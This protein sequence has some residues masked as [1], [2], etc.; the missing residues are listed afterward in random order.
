[1]RRWRSRSC[2][3]RPDRSRPDPRAVAIAALSLLEALLRDG[4]VLLAVDDAQ[5]LDRGHGA[6]AHLRRSASAGPS[7]PHPAGSDRSRRASAARPVGR[8]PAGA[9]PAHP[10]GRHAGQRPRGRDPGADGDRDIGPRGQASRGR[11][12]RQSLLR[13]RDRAGRGPRRPGCHRPVPSHPEEPPRGPRHASARRASGGKPRSAARRGGRRPADAR[14]PRRRR[15]G[16]SDAGAA[17][18][19]DRRRSR[20]GRRRRRSLHAPAVPVGAVR[21]RLEGPAP[22][23][24]STSRGPHGRSRGASAAPRSVGGVHGRGDRRR[25]GR[26]GG[27]GAGPRRPRRGGG[28][29]RARDPV[30]TALG[31]P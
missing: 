18:A 24:A 12:G 3:G 22:H 7:R 28:T 26:G 13:A 25:A 10:A 20:R 8:A 21:E 14:P 15:R 29:V 23:R 11:L 19:R 1:M 17:P 6:R 2:G 9:H 30:D 5:W 31:G 27:A 4:P 16:R